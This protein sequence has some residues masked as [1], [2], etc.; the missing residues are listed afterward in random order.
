MDGVDCCCAVMLEKIWGISTQQTTVKRCVFC[1]DVTLT[2]A[3]VRTPDEKM[4]QIPLDHH[5]I[6]AIRSVLDDQ[7]SENIHLVIMS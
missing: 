3:Y 2:L 6:P 1:C 4:S 7:E 5:I